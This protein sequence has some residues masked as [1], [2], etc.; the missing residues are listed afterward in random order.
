MTEDRVVTLTTLCQ[1]R[2]IAYNFLHTYFLR[3]Y[4]LTKLTTIL[5]TLLA[6]LGYL[7]LSNQDRTYD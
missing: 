2:V 7:T 1:F 5:G 4:L 3:N 6:C